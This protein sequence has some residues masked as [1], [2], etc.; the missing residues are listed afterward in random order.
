LISGTVSDAATASGL[1]NV[2]VSAYDTASTSSFSTT[3]AA[4]GT[5]SLSVPAGT[6][7]VAFQDYSGGHLVQWWNDQPDQNSANPVTVTPGATTAGI[8]GALTEGGS[9]AG[10][11]TNSSSQPLAGVCATIYS[12]AND[13]YAN[14]GGCSDSAGR[15]QTTGVPA[16]SYT[17]LF[18]DTA[19]QTCPSGGTAKPANLKPPP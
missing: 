3:T 5:Y 18:T 6:Y 17:V 14:A 12:A 15:Y 8:D 19:G 10:T 13:L 9:I 2:T 4:G 7:L 16:G 11:V 1:A